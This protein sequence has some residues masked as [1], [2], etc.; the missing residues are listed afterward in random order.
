[1]A[2]LGVETAYGVNFGKYRVIDVLTTKR[3]DGTLRRPK[4]HKKNEAW[5]ERYPF[6]FTRKELL[7]G[8]PRTPN[9]KPLLGAPNI[10]GKPFG[11]IIG[12]QVLITQRLR[13]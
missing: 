3:Y 2:I 11:G 4:F 13:P 8:K 9:K 12:G 5:E 7:Q 6:K 1:M 10:P